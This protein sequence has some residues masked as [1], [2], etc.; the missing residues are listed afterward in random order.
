MRRP[1]G[2]RRC[3]SC[4][5]DHIS[6]VSSDEWRVTNGCWLYSSLDTCHVS[7]FWACKR[8]VSSLILSRSER[9]V[10]VPPGPPFFVFLASILQRDVLFRKQIN[11][12]RHRMLAPFRRPLT[13][14]VA[15]SGTAPDGLSL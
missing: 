14:I 10:R 11:P 13:D 4:C 15:A 5:G 2:L 7:L 1:F 6:E 9:R 3:K 8:G 12:G